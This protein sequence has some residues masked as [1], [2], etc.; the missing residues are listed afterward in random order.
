MKAVA[1]WFIYGAH[2]AAGWAGRQA[3]LIWPRPLTRCHTLPLPTSQEKWTGSCTGPS[4]GS[5]ALCWQGP[6]SASV[7]RRG[8]GRGRGAEE[9]A[10][11][12]ASAR[13]LQRPSPSRADRRA[14]SPD[15]LAL[16]RRLGHL[17]GRVRA[18]AGGDGARLPL[19]AQL[20]RDRGDAGPGADQRTAPERSGRGGRQHGRG[21]R[22]AAP[23]ARGRGF[24]V[25]EG[26]PLL[27]TS[28][29]RGRR[30]GAGPGVDGRG[31]WGGAAHGRVVV[32]RATGLEAHT[33]VHSPWRRCSSGRGCGCCSASSRRLRPWVGA[34]WCWCTARRSRSLSAWE[35]CVGG[36]TGQGRGRCG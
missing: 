3:S 29:R 25:R 9:I 35:W 22:G 5:G 19:Q 4:F 7:R 33:R 11:R 14:G 10:L 16:P 32:R 12:R 36:W 28:E 13:P 34:S 18:C 30:L 26:A 8:R 15:A 1:D 21:R 2:L 27:G 24:G 6:S 17:G 31:G 23:G 20:A